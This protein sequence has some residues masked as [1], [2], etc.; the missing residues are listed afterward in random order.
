MPVASTPVSEMPT[1]SERRTDSWGNGVHI[2]LG[3]STCLRH[4]GSWLA[5]VRELL[6]KGST[7]ADD[8]WARRHRGILTLLWLHLPVIVVVV[9]CKGSASCTRC[10]RHP[11]SSS[12]CVGAVLLRT[13]RRESTIFTALGLLTCSA[14]LVHLTDGIIEMHF[15]Y[16]VMVGVITLYQDWWPFLVAIGY[17]VFQHGVAGAVAPESVYNHQSAVDHPWEWAGIPRRVRP[18]MSVA[19]VLSWKLNERQLEAT[20]DREEKLSEAQAVA[21]LGNWEFDLITRSTTWSAEL[22]RLIGVDP[23]TEPTIDAFVSQVHEGRPRRCARHP[24]R[25]GR[26]GHGARDGTSA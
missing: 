25:R 7:L 11:S 24:A 14:V 26:E 21:H 8:V 3:R 17:V 18:R 16:F 23:T 2:Q 9:S 20:T 1:T 22:F 6:P 15:H 4:E 13:H 5:T 12:F 19:G 10:S